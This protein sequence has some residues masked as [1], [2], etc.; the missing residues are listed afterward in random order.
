MS[1][2]L[3]VQAVAEG[4]E[5]SGREVDESEEVSDSLDVAAAEADEAVERTGCPK[6]PAPTQLDS[7]SRSNGRGV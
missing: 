2:A 7:R 3:D 1:L 5:K 6:S 4:E